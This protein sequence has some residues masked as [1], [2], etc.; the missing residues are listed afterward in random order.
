MT[1]KIL[2][3]TRE[4]W[5][6]DM[7]RLDRVAGTMYEVQAQAAQDGMAD[8]QQEVMEDLKSIQ[9]AKVLLELLLQNYQWKEE[10]RPTQ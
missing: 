1:E 7:M 6:M 4:E 5:Q 8:V 3:H 2:D 9:R 10:A